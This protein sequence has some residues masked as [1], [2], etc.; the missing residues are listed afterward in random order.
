MGPTMNMCGF[1]KE[2]STIHKTMAV[3]VVVLY[4][5]VVSTI[6]LFHKDECQAT[7]TDAAHKDGIPNADQCPACTF[8]AGHSSTGAS[9]GPAL[10]IAESLLISQFSPRVTVLQHNEWAYSIISR[11]PPS[12]TIS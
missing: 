9:H 7:P 11:A 5:L 8:L 10:V 4:V 3:L 1:S 6:D 12:A 2:G